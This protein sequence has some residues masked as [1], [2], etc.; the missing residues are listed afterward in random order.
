VM[1]NHYNSLVKQRNAELQD[2]QQFPARWTENAWRLALVFHAAKHGNAAHE[3]PVDLEPC[4]DALTVMDWFSNAQMSLLNKGGTRAEKLDEEVQKLYDRVSGRESKR[5]TLGKLRD[6]Y[7]YEEQALRQLVG[8]SHGKLIIEETK[9]RTK[10]K[11][12]VVVVS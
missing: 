8:K 11:R 2:I 6:S 10:T 1:F 7:C 9:T 4:Q 3:S 12:E 5:M